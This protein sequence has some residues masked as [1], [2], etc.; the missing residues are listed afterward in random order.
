M[1][2]TSNPKTILILYGSETG[3]CESISKRIHQEAGAKG[4]NSRWLALNSYREV[5]LFY[6]MSS[7]LFQSLEA[8]ET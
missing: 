8:I 1:H 5:F 6:F 7:L 4:Y 2:K 3:N